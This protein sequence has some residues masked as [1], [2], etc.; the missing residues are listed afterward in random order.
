MITVRRGNF[1][2]EV[3]FSFNK[4]IV[5]SDYYSLLAP[6]AVSYS[7]GVIEL[8]FKEVGRIQYEREDQSKLRR[9]YDNWLSVPITNQ[10]VNSAQGQETGELNN[11]KIP[12]FNNQVIS[13]VIPTD[14]IRQLADGGAE[15]SLSSTPTDSST[16][17]FHDS[18]QNDNSVISTTTPHYYGGGGGGGA[19]SP[20]SSGGGGVAVA[21]DVPT[22]TPTS[23]TPT[24]T[25]TTT[26]TSTPPVETPSSTPT[27]TPPADT[28]TTTPTSTPPVDTPTSTPTSTPDTVPPS[29]PTVI[30][31]WPDS[32]HP[33]LHL[34][35]TSTDASSSEV[36]FDIFYATSSDWMEF[37]SNSSSAEYD[38]I[39][40]RGN[41]Y[42]FRVNAL[43]SCGNISTSSQST[44]TTL[45]Y[46]TLAG[47]QSETV[48]TLTK[49]NNPYIANAYTVPVG[50][51]LNIEP[52]VQ[53]KIISRTDLDIKG[54]FS[55]IGSA[56]DRIRFEPYS[57]GAYWGQFQ[58]NNAV[59]SASYTDFVSGNSL[60]TKPDAYDG[61]LLAQNSII[62]LDNDYLWDIYEYGNVVQARYS[63]TTIS[64][65][66]IG[67]A[68]IS[69]NIWVPNRGIR[70]KSG[71]LHLDNVIFQNLTYGV[72][73]GSIHDLDLT[74]LYY[75][76]L[77]DTN[78][79]NVERPFV[80]SGWPNLVSST[81]V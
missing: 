1:S 43:D 23:T 12:I 60:I 58:I 26:P 36:F 75:T 55:A 69:S 11:A 33:I 42:L 54:V 40:A 74:S 7:A 38:F 14:H 66:V 28:P 80:P 71:E 39:G 52:G 34:S 49:D 16:S 57:P 29:A 17:S 9:I 3:S 64:N 15:K 59:F 31:T 24:D 5:H 63:T 79:V 30:V 37:I 47:T 50:A 4:N 25:P 6:K 45:D 20:A 73:G 53:V 19:L 10:I 27:S 48:R 56:D 8:F 61:M 32:N 51:T 77:S 44:T 78:F 46:I 13:P 18:V 65:S 21:D 62:N 35:V 76:N 68:E 81:P 70:V 72:L 22:T 41:S 2:G 67:D